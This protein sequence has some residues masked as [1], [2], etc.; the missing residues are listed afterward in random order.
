MRR[1]T[2]AAPL[3]AVAHAQKPSPS[4][5]ADGAFQAFHALT[6][7]PVWSARA[8]ARRFHSS[9]FASLSTLLEAVG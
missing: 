3:S 5:R 1:D 9:G 4:R 6:A 7:F 8:F 2:L